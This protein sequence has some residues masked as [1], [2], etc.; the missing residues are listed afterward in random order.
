MTPKASPQGGKQSKFDTSTLVRILLGYEEYW[1]LMIILFLC[2]VSAAVCYF[3]Y[4]KAT[5]Q[6][7][8]LIRVNSFIVGSDAAQ[9]LAEGDQTYRQMRALVDQLNS[10]YIVLEAAKKIGVADSKTTFDA[11]RENVMPTIRVSMLDQSHLEVMILSFRQDVVRKMPQALVDAYE[12][13]RVKMRAEYRDQAIKRYA[14]EIEEV[15][16]K[17]SEQLSTKLQFEEQSALANAQ[18]EMERLSNIPV[19]IVRTKYRMKEHEE[20]DTVLKTQGQTLDTVGKLSL[21]TNFTDAEKDPLEAGR[22]VRKPSGTSPFTFSSPST[23][24]KVTQV[25]VQ[26]NMVEGLKP[27]QELEKTKRSLEEKLR[28]TRTKFLEDHPE[29]MKLK[30][31]IKQLET[32]LEIEL[33]VALTAFDLEK[34]RLTQR[35]AELETKLPEYHKATKSYDVKKQDYDLME[36]S[37]L[38]WDKAYEKLSQRVEGLQFDSNKAALTLEFRGFTDL[39]ADTPV[40]PSKSKLIMLG[41]L[42]GIGL[43]G[44]VPFMLRRFDS[45]VVELNEFEGTTGIAGI[46]LVPLT[47]PK[48]LEA[49]N[50]SPTIGAT[51][52][53][54]LLENFRLIRS[55]ILLN[56][57]P[58]G[59]G[60]VIMITSARPGEG[61]TTVSSNIAWAFSSLGERTLLIDCDLRRG[62]VH[63]VVG[64]SNEKGVTDLLT[65]RA[66]IDECMQK[67]ET[68]NLWVIPR[69]AVVPGTTELL[70]SGVF[71]VILEKLKDK[72][73]RVILDTP[74]VLGLSETAFLQHHAD[75]IVLI[76]RCGVTL[77]KDV[78]DAVHTLQKLGGHFYGFVLNGVDFSKR[79]NHY[80]YYYYS[81]SYYDANWDEK[82]VKKLSHSH[83]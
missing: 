79:A 83:S 33:K 78:E 18:I 42:F 36:K 14:E 64:A 41:L 66:T 37:Q 45:S 30:E 73:D 80:H 11:L 43:A 75:G 19:D 61:K 7:Y 8:G 13:I 81:A 28:F 52:P 24:K 53:N 16:K 3:V 77:R 6:S 44:G 34:D 56:K 67:T 49:L 71:S 82:P 39:R 76:V 55:S 23:D 57:S 15:R 74:P 22:V 68:D 40:S 20:I 32:A 38:A 50:R 59:E 62:R 21:V 54:A 47:E 26:P 60:R 72:F 29:V 12:E 70:N 17:V 1:R 35:V 65:G 27:W 25:V 58:K 5:F 31:E 10:G 63:G 9:G 48:V 4:A 46:G 2:G 69:G 51:I